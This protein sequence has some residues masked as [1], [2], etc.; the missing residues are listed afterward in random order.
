MV[1]ILIL[2]RT[3]FGMVVILIL[4]RTLFLVYL[5]ACRIIMSMDMYCLKLAN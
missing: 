5:M 1:V 3:L 4:M 2:M